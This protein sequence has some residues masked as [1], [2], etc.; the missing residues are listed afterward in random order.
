MKKVAFFVFSLLLVGSVFLSS[1]STLA[2]GTYTGIGTADGLDGSADSINFSQGR[3]WTIDQYGKYIWLTEGRSPQNHHWAWSNDSGANWTQGSESYSFLNRGSVAYDSI[4]DVLHVIWTG[5][6]DT[7][8]VIYRRYSITRDGSNNITAIARMDSG[9]VNLQLDT[10]ASRNLEQPI[11]IWLNDGSTDGTLIA[12]WSKNGTSL[13]EVRASMRRLS[14]TGSDGTAGNWVALDGTGDT[15]STDSPA[16]EADK[17]YGSTTTGSAI[18]GAKIRGGSGSRKDDMYIFVAENVGAN[19]RILAYRGIWSSSN[20]NW[21]GGWQSPVV[22]GQMN[23]DTGG[24]SLKYQLITKP[25]VD[26]TND[27]LYI[28]WARFKT[29]GD[30]DTVSFAYLDSTD[31]A[32]SVFDAYS[33]LGTHSYAPTLDIAFDDTRDELY[34][35]YVESTTNGTNGSIDYKVFDGTTLGSQTRFYTNTTGSAGANGSADIPILYQSRTTND[36]LLFA[37]R[38]NGA[39][40]PTAGNPHKI[41]WGYITLAAAATP[42][43]TPTPDSSQ[44]L[45]A[46]SGENVSAPSCS[47]SAPSGV[48]DLFQV[49][50]GG[51]FVNLNFTTVTGNVSGYQIS[52]G[53]NTNDSQYGD[54]YGYSGPKWVVNRV[55]SGLSPNTSYSFKVRTVNGCNAGGWSK[56]VQVKTNGRIA[57]L[58]ARFASLNPFAKQ[59]TPAGTS[60][61]VAKSSDCT[62]IVQSGDSLWTIAQNY[63]GSGANF[64]QLI[65]YNPE[66]FTGN[67]SA[68]MIRI[69]W[70]LKVC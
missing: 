31:A 19:S 9:T 4:N 48:P 67:F 22:V 53:L 3:V 57:D 51:T 11:A 7:D 41:D 45:T 40:P 55:V 34:I 66:I 62:Y 36:R 26:T 20:T 46:P 33:A 60:Q 10:S 29:G 64:S 44:P 42:T 54:F 65:G 69:G 12:I 13:T 37:F 27:R 6:D 15:F 38:I 16:V 8:G 50:A 58:T 23:N 70:K 5:E 17:I 2:E 14:M 30:G 49:D 24:Y 1:K 43:P 56:T 59:P 35:S 32:S 63:L 68:S 52:Y 47:D 28:G 18:A 39:L 25:V 61:P 21:S